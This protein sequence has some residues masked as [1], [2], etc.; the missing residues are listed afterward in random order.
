MKDLFLTLIEQLK[1]TTAQTKLVI[2]A[3]IVLSL[4][5]AGVMAYR[6]ANPHMELLYGSLNNREM[7]DVT[8]ALSTAGVRFEVNSVKAPYNI[9]VASDQ[10]HAAHAAIG[11]SSA[12]SAGPKG[13]IPGGGGMKSTFDDAGKRLQEGMKRDWQDLELQLE[14]YNFVEAAIVRISGPPPSPI[15]PSRA[16]TVSVVLHITGGVSLDQGV[17]LAIAGTVCK[18][19]GTPEENVTITDQNGRIVFDGQSDNSQNEMLRFEEEW[20]RSKSMIAQRALSS[21]GDNLVTVTVAGTYDF[22]MSESVQ[23]QLTPKGTVISEDT[24]S[25]TTPID[26][27]SGQPLN[28]AGGPAGVASNL[29]ATPTAIHTS[30][31]TETHSS[32]K[33]GVGRTMTHVADTAP[34]LTRMTVAV[35]VHESL[36]DSLA[37]IEEIVKNAIGFDEARGD[38]I[39]VATAPMTHIEVDDAGQPVQAAIEPAPEPPNKMMA[40][41]LERGVEILAAGAFLLVLLKSLKKGV[42]K[43]EEVAAATSPLD[44]IN[45]EDLDLDML[46]RK[47]VEQMLEEDPEKVAALLSRWALGENFYAGAE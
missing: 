3:A 31:A 1:A 23:E 9:F 12:L 45:E 7:S 32:K 39:A 4:G 19:T 26:L 43:P 29:S 24:D 34:T 41:L 14:T 21:Y 16:P 11:S 25:S 5:A 27:S 47:H 2:A 44:L 20:A 37:D 38:S 28:S 17:R 36:K 8:Q 15:L 10:I 40:M 30:E 6:S 22:K 35:S 18:G 13:I 42:A 46:A 33:F